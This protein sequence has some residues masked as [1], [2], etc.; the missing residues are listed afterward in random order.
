MNIR[1]FNIAKG[2]LHS[3]NAQK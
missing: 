1:I 2:Y 3:F